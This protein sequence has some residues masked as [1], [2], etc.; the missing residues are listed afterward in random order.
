MPETRL[1]QEFEDW[2]AKAVFFYDPAGNIV[3][4]IARQSS[5]PAT[6]PFG[7]DSVLCVSEIGIPTSNVVAR[8]KELREKY[9]IFSFN[10]HENTHNFWALGADHGLLLVVPNER[11]WFPTDKPARAFPLQLRFENRKNIVCELEV[12]GGDDVK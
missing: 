4:F 1:I 8:A 7:V 11:A 9:D 10:K 2:E 6:P 12:F 5:R 3:E